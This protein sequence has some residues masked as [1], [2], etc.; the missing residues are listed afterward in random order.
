MESL[1][2]EFRELLMEFDKIGLLDE[3]TVIGSWAKEIY[4]ENL[5][6]KSSI[7]KTLDIDFALNNPKS[8]FTTSLNNLLLMMEYKPALTIH[9]KSVTYFPSSEN[10][11]LNIDF[12]C[13]YSRKITEPTNIPGLNIVVTP[14]K[15]QDILIKNSV[16]FPYMGLTVKVPK[17]EIW[18]IHKISI[19]QQRQG[20][21]DQKLNKSMADLDS[22]RDLIDYFGLDKLNQFAEENF[23]GKFLNYYSE[24]IEK[25]KEM[26]LGIE[27]ELDHG[28]D[29]SM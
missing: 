25:L 7:I 29:F 10:R 19:S 11:E 14:L 15:Y 21:K 28:F 9:S 16:S 12:L 18:T 24:G 13:S 23:K 4:M 22:T 5:P 1:K 27:Q 20:T 26:G 2:K 17:P 6:I 3:F 8:P